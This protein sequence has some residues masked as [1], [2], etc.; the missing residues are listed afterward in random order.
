MMMLVI[1]IGCAQEK[2][3]LSNIREG[4][5]GQSRTGLRTG[6]LSHRLEKSKVQLV[7]A[8]KTVSS[9][10]APQASH[11]RVWRPEYSVLPVIEIDGWNVT[12]SNVRDSRY[13]SLT[14]YDVRY[15]D[16]AFSLTDLV[17]VDFVVV[18]FKKSDFLAHTMLAFGLRDNRHFLVS[19]EARLE[20]DEVYSTTA[21]LR[22]QFELMYVIGDERD[23]I[24]LR[25]RIRQVDCYLYPGRA[26]PN[27]VQ[28]LFLDIANRVNQIARTP[29]YYH[30]VTNNCT[31]NLVDH[32]NNVFPERIPTNDWRVLLPGRSDSLAFELGLLN[33]P[34]LNF[35]QVKSH[36][37][38]NEQAI[39][40]ENDPGFSTLIRSTRLQ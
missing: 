3:Q 38:I 8:A 17:T 21:G 5:L 9:K 2:S 40:Y 28:K 36:Y 23:L 15:Y 31:T 27:D 20:K 13:R 29:E 10:V 11:N 1:V 39:Y 12:I 6:E 22:N 32:V 7:S 34:H 30:T 4:K 24:P 35:E 16:M 25:T 26:A 33:V 19:V 18:P 14:D 37:R